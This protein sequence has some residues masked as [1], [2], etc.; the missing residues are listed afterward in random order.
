MSKIS[1][2]SPAG[3]LTGEELIEL[4][5]NGQNVRG[6]IADLVTAGKSAYDVAVENGFVGTETEWIDSLRGKGAFE[7]AVELGFS[8]TES[9]WVNGLVG[10]SAYDTAVAAGF[11]GTESEWLVSLKGEVGERGNDGLSAYQIALSNGFVGTEQDWLNSLK[12]E[13]GAKG[14]KGD[15]GDQGESGSTSYDIA[16]ANGF[17]GTE[18]EWV[19]LVQQA[20]QGGVVKFTDLIVTKR[21]D[22]PHNGIPGRYQ[23]WAYGT[24]EDLDQVTVSTTD[25]TTFE[26]TNVPENLTLKSMH[27]FYDEGYN[28]GTAFF[29][30]YPDPY[31]DT[32][33][34]GIDM[35]PPLFY[36]YNHG[37]PTV[38]QAQSLQGYTNENGIITLQKTALVSGRAARFRIDFT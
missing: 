26:I 29:L 28:Q 33:G 18:A 12:G 7:T 27:L 1:M 38:L 32:D 20:A 36:M 14:D 19:S 6:T 34:D 24:Q 17:S 30:K 23:M 3:P 9:E 10:A 31:G 2:M 37:V 15:K 21:V 25:G 5:Q 11:S 8:G 16:V 4:V 35:W 22:L 13:S